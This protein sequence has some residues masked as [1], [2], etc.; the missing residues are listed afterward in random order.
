MQLSIFNQFFKSGTSIG[1]NYCE[2]T[3]ASSKKDFSN[4]ISISK[5]KQRKLNID[6]E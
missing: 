4:K 3:E 5:K 6:L 1:A 2:A